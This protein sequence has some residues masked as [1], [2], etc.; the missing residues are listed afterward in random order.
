MEVQRQV[1][2]ADASRPR[3]Q[4][5]VIRRG[6]LLL[7]RDVLQ[8]E[9][10]AQHPGLHEP[11]CLQTVALSGRN[12]L[13]TTTDWYAY[14]RNDHSAFPYQSNVIARSLLDIETDACNQNT[15]FYYGKLGR[16][17]YER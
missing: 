13:K 9:A 12:G 1:I 3:D 8:P 10:S 17:D 6:S 5:G 15:V 11:G 16:V 14:A 7:H 4:S 2:S